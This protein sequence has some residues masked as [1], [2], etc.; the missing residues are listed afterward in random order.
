VFLSANV[1]ADGKLTTSARI[2]VSRD[3]VK[4]PQ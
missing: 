1:G 4:P 2:Q 3:G